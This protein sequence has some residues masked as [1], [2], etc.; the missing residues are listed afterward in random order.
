MEANPNVNYRYFVQP[1][2]S[3]IHDWQSLSPN[4]E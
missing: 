1:S 4:L 2:A 3:L